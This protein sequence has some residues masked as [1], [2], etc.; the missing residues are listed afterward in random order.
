M[1]DQR[2][3]GINAI[4][5]ARGT[6]E[7]TNTDVLWL[8]DN[9]E[10]NIYTR[11]KVYVEGSWELIS[12]VP[13]QVLD[14]LRSVDGAGSG[15]DADTL[16]GYTPEQLM[17]ESGGEGV[18][19]LGLGQLL[20]GQ[21]DNTGIAK[22]VG[23]IVTMDADGNM[24]YVTNSISHTGLT[25]VGTNT[26]A[27]IDSH[28]SSTSNPHGVTA[29]QVGNTVSQWNAD[30]IEGNTTNIGS[31]GAAQDGQVMI[32]DN[33]TS[34]FI[35]GAAGAENLNDLTD[36]NTGLPVPTTE[37]DTGKLLYYDHSS[38][39]WKTDEAVTHGTVVINGKKDSAGTIAKGLP[40]YLVGFDSDLH[41]VEL[42]DA[43]NAS[44]MP[45]I[46][47]SAESMNNTDSKHIITF[48]KL[49]GIDT[50]STV[51]QLNPNGETWA[52]ND[53]LYISTNT[54][55]L[56]KVRPTGSGSLIQRVAKV[57]KVDATGGQIF[58]FNTARTAGLPNLTTDNVWVGD[59]NGYP[60]MVNKNTLGGNTIYT[61]DDTIGS[62]RIA[63][64]TDTL[65]FKGSDTS[66]L[67]SNLK[68]LDSASST[69]WDFRNNGD[70][71]IGQ[72]TVFE[73][74]AFGFVFNRTTGLNTLELQTNGANFATFRSALTEIAS[75]VIHLGSIGGSNGL[76][77]EGDRVRY[78]TSVGGA[79]VIHDIH[80]DRFALFGQGFST[81]ANSY[82]SIGSFTRIGTENVSLQGETFIKGNDTLS[83]STALAI[84]DGDATPSKLW[85]FRNNGD[86]YQG[87]DS[88][89]YLQGNDFT[90]STLSGS[91][92]PINFE[93]GTAF[94]GYYSRWDNGG[95]LV[96]KSGTTGAAFRVLNKV[97][98]TAQIFRVG[99]EG[100]GFMSTNGARLW[101]ISETTTSTTKNE[102]NSNR[103][104][105]F[106]A[107]TEYHRIQTGGGASSG[108][109][110]F[111]VGFGSLGQFIVGGTALIGTEDISLQGETLIDG[112]LDMNS[113]RI[114]NTVINP[115]VQE[116][117]S[118]ATFTINADEETMGVLTAMAAATTI[119]APTGT[120]VQ[121]QKLMLRFKDDGTSRALTW[122]AVWRAIGVTLPAAT[123]ASKTLYIGAVYNSTDSKWDV[124]AVKEEA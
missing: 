16:R 101:T 40:V 12:R 123:T 41:T 86:I 13:S 93:F 83:T 122:N 72:N 80:A 59:V 67:S 76:K 119:A 64:L 55:G 27:Q 97:D 82:F 100:G 75:S 52:V 74:G 70:V 53:V 63:T 110:F 10:G 46:G 92:T 103:I 118:T 58:I 24:L 68:I 4:A 91:T 9:I 6:S 25:D 23:G 81:P 99:N 113:N 11:L 108:V 111:R 85:D 96:I 95:G 44:A 5:I 77:I 19:D 87:K 26:H 42:A 48:G 39:E 36:V 116:T 51:S 54:G 8:D 33:A 106:F 112:T 37:A 89:Q 30:K 107:G 114:T 15:L 43:N 22:T 71:Y 34:R 3:Q 66:V 38:G 17:E 94:G 29:G 121:G 32:W 79:G 1:A 56:T 120:P 18:P 117:T 61:A 90:I 7:P 47:F 20:V 50:T 31:L 109:F 124:I 115:S 21:T 69:L 14:D 28:I 35:M 98:A 105:Q 78:Y 45:V 84:Y 73:G 65:S 104:S 49:E 2:I 60:Q 102:F 57:L 88:I 62:G